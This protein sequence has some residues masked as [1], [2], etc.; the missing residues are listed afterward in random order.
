[1]E[2]DPIGCDGQWKWRTVWHSAHALKEGD[3][4]GEWQTS[5]AGDLEH[6][7]HEDEYQSCLAH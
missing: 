2:S 5:Y 1:M 7:D 6:Q 4:N 3:E